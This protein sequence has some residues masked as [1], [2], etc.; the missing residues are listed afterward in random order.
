MTPPA[1]GSTAPPPTTTSAT[2]KSWTVTTN[3][4][5][6]TEPYFIRLS[7]TGDPNAAI[8]YNLGNGGPDADQRA[9]M[10]AGFLELPAARRVAH[11]RPDDRPLVAARRRGHRAGPPASG[12]A[13]TATASTPPAPRTATATATSTTRPS[14]TVQG[15][16]WAGVCGAQGQNQGSGHLWPVLAGERAEHEIATGDRRRP[17]SCWPGMAAHRVRHRADPRTGLGEPGSGRVAV[18]HRAPEC[19]SIGFQNG[20]AAG[21]ASPLTWSAAQFVRLSANI[22]AGRVTEWPVDTTRRYIRNTQTGDGRHAHR[23]G[24]QLGDQWR[25]GDGDRQHRAERAGRR[26]RREHRRQR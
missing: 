2:I 21:S 14:C 16:P 8:T 18:R 10:D 25:S 6:S 15:K 24:R 11:R 23:A 17:S 4:P 1:P 13:S 20:K 12:R 9:V 22:R 7:K 3:G 26:R 19:A 5:L